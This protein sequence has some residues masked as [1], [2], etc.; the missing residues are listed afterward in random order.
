METHNLMAG[1]RPIYTRENSRY[2]QCSTYLA[3]K[4]RRM[5]TKEDSLAHAKEIAEDWYLELRGKSRAG[6]LKSGPT[7]K[8]ASDRF[9]LEYETLTVGQRNPRYIQ[10][11]KDRLRL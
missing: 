5:T 4:N 7:F 10:S 3:G 2:W 8:Q 1:K 9:L 6:Q 11:Q